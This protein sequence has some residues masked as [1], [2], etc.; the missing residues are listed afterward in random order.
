MRSGLAYTHTLLARPYVVHELRFPTDPVDRDYTTLPPPAA[1]SLE[2]RNIASVNGVWPEIYK[3]GVVSVSAAPILHSVPCVGYV[4]QEAPVPGKM[5]PKSYVPH[6]KRTRTPMSVMSKLQQGESVTLTD[7]TVLQGPP[8]RPGRKIVILG[9]T[10]DPSPIIPLAGG[11][12]LLV[13]EATNAHLPGLDLNTKDAD[14]YETVQ[15]RAMSRGHST[16]QM[17]GKFARTI[18]AK[19]LILNHFSAR[20]PGDESEESLRIMGA[21]GELAAQEFG[22]AVICARDFTSVDIGFEE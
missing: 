17:A 21:I 20:Y 4:V 1:E 11:A 7:G 12:D 5:E 22:K 19:R 14:T 13:H 16:P 2:G 3:D 10:Y 6:L 18:G 9:D 8:R 15:E